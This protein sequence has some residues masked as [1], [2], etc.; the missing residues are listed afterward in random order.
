MER[1]LLNQYTANPQV[2]HQERFLTGNGT[3]AG[4]D[5]KTDNN[6]AIQSNTNSTPENLQ[7]TTN[8]TTK[9]TET[10]VKPEVKTEVQPETKT[11]ETEV[12]PQDQK[13]TTDTGATQTT[14]LETS[15]TTD[16]KTQA[17]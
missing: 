15:T 13:I 8:P 12:K 1:R 10:E 4:T 16:E 3:T 6:V 2:L 17:T 9:T 7:V 14:K 11:V 5:G